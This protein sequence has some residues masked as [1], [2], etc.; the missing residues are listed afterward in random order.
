[1]LVGKLVW[2][3]VDGTGFGLFVG[4]SV[5]FFDGGCV[6]CLVGALVGDKDSGDVGL[7]VGLCV[8]FAG[9]WN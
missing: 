9:R 4:E 7:L 1:L 5:G 3:A 6:G 2:F 8:G